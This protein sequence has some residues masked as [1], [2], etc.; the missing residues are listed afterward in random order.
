M[1]QMSPAVNWTEKDLTTTVVGSGTTGG[2]FAGIFKWGPVLK[3]VLLDSEP[4]QVSRFGKPDDNCF[5]D[6]F[7][8]ANFLSY[9]T[10]LTAVRV[11][12]TAAKNASADGNGVLIKN[13]DHYE[14]TYGAGAGNNGAWAAKYPGDLGNS[15]TVSMAD[16]GSFGTWTYKNYFTAAP[17][18][19]TFAAGYNATNDELHVVVV[20]KS[21]AWT[22]VAGTVL[23]RFAF[24]SKASNA[25]KEDGTSNYYATVLNRASDYVWWTDHPTLGTN[26]GNAALDTKFTLLGTTLV[27]DEG[28]TGTFV[29]GET[30]ATAQNA[31]T[32]KVMSWDGTTRTLIVSP[33]IGAF[34]ADDEI[35][36]GTSSATG[37][38]GTATAPVL[39][40]PL[41]GGVD[42]NDTISD[43]E[44][45]AGYDLFL[46]ED[47]DVGLV[48]S[49]DASDALKLY[50][51]G[52]IAE[53]RK[54][55]VAF[56]SPKR[57][58]VVNNAGNE[59]D[60]ILVTR[61]A[62][63]SSSYAFMDG[64]WKYQYDKYN[65]TFR[66]L[67]LNGDIAGLAVRTDE[68]QD[69]WF[70]FA[71]L[72]RG[73]IKN[74]VKLAWNPVKTQRDVLYSNGVNPV[75]AFRGEGPV[76]F[77][78]K[79]LQTKPSAFDHINVRRLFIILEK[80]IATSAKYVLFDFND[81]FTR[82]QFRSMIIPF[83]R[84]VKGRRGIIDF[85]VV[86]DSTNNS[87]QVI[88]TNNFTGDIYIKPA[89]SINNIQLNFVATPDSV[90]F[91][92]I[93]GRA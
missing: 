32:A 9:G 29:A 5:I 48:L 92:E 61:N 90:S 54:D 47:T 77:G 57:D 24:V 35:T 75:L 39:S 60:D 6:F 51:I 82:S 88:D 83:L 72:N 13:V 4:T 81:E 26:W 14:E 21:G 15:L 31:K 86:C 62:L 56:L 2:A 17:G 59:V 34:A 80:S 27:L 74:V 64:N 38:I 52:N 30:V 85:E 46:S 7:T 93:V 89:R 50:L 8:C 22:G 79:T 12:S 71:G 70:S 1:F 40:Y 63:T 78:D 49:G 66:W 84:D 69:P 91:N 36:G 55:C 20:D 19:S 65:D 10:N 18:T 3:K 87:A 44:K 53:V 73:H 41:T 33:V 43:A 58:D 37:T 28:A 16:A 11:V 25:K 23:E 67:P 45:M 76:L 42:G 68:E